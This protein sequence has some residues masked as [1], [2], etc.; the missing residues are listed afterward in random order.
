M[1]RFKLLSCLIL[2]GCCLCV[3]KAQTDVI[4]TAVPFLRLSPDARGASLGNSGAATTPDVN[5]QYWNAAKYIFAERSYGAALNYSSLKDQMTKGSYGAYVAGY[6]K[7]DDLQSI[8]ASFNVFVYS[9]DIAFKDEQNQPLG[10][11]KP[12]DYTID[13]AYARKLNEYLSAAVTARYVR[14]DLTY[15]VRG[16]GDKAGQAVAT[17]LALYFAK[18]VMLFGNDFDLS[19]GAVVSNLGTKISYNEYGKSS[20][21]PTNARLG[22]MLKYRQEEVHTMA[23]TA[24]VNRLLVSG[25]GNYKSA[26]WKEFTASVGLEYTYLDMFALRGGYFGESYK[27]GAGSFF[28]F[29]A[30]FKYEM[31]TIDIAYLVP[32]NSFYNRNTFKLGLQVEF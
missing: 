5:A 13:L 16:N 23:V 26:G 1:K 21:L 22:A 24:D 20:N 27:R 12:M 15:D 4:T 31:L 18:P 29:G 32:D 25:L 6:Y 17:D 19:V 7:L 9:D 3:A 8:S 28:S 10:S 14:S 30:G 11:H 2:F